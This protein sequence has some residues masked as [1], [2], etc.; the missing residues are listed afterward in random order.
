MLNGKTALITGSSLGIGYAVAEKL[1]SLGCNV[2]MNGIEPTAEIGPKAET[3]ANANGI[4]AVYEA[5]DVGDGPAL[6]AVMDRALADFGGIDIVVNNAVTRIFGN[7]ED[8]DP[9][10]WENAIDVNLN[11]AFRTIHHAMPGMKRNGWGRIVNM[12]SIYGQIGAADRASYVTSKTALI[13]LTRA[14][15]LEVAAHEDITCN[16]VSPGTVRTTYADATIRRAMAQDGLD[17][18]E[19]VQRFLDGKSP[20]GRFVET[21]SVA[22]LV[23]FLC[24]SAGR[25]INGA[26]LPI[27]HGWSAA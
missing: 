15:A 23:A 19:A 27:D 26:V 11:S 20:S 6:D 14:V 17:E 9:A 8:T 5:C 10:D 12:S 3:L 24:G 16:A 25:D 21:G 7:V 2:V 4:K 22:E 1:A 18:D 13:G